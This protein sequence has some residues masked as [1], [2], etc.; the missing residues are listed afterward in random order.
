M[1]QLHLNGLKAT[2]DPAVAS[3]SAT[4]WLSCIAIDRAAYNQG[5]GAK[6]DFQ[7][8]DDLAQTLVARGP[9]GYWTCGKIVGSLNYDDYKGPNRQYVEQGKLVISPR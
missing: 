5:M 6:Y 1:Q 3:Q 9:G 2:A 4:T 8:W 7:V